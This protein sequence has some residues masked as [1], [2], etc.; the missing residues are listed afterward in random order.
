MRTNR[1]RKKNKRERKGKDGRLKSER[2]KQGCGT[3]IYMCHV[4]VMLLRTERNEKYKME[5]GKV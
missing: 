4:R 3:S 2:E 5:G 1:G